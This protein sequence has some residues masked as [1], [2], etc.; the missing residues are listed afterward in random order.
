MVCN[1][2]AGWVRWLFRHPAVLHCTSIAW[3]HT[4]NTWPAHGRVTDTPPWRSDDPEHLPLTLQRVDLPLTL[5][6]VDLSCRRACAFLHTE[7]AD[8]PS[9]LV[10]NDEVNEAKE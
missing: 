2:R 7:S 1:R 3:L 5:Q 10:E 8:A 9:W 4:A 6:R